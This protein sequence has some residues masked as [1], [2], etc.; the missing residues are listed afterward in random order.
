VPG[1]AI[2]SSFGKILH[3]DRAHKQQYFVDSAHVR[4]PSECVISF[5]LDYVQVE[6]PENCEP[7]N[8]VVFG[9]LVRI[10]Q[11]KILDL[12]RVKRYFYII[13]KLEKFSLILN[14]VVLDESFAPICS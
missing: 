6:A 4:T 9:E 12:K 8:L 1:I 14:L 7:N 5:A 11:P 2:L 13:S 3:K 10:A